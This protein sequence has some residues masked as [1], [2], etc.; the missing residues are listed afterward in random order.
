M[1]KMEFRNFHLEF[2]AYNRIFGF[3]KGPDGYTISKNKRVYNLQ[4]PNA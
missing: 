4:K 1:G 2:C 3:R